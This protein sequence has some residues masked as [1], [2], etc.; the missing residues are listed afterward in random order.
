M[1]VIIFKHVALMSL[2]LALAGCRQEQERQTQQG[3][4]VHANSSYQQHFGDP[5]PVQA[6]KAYARVIYLPLKGERMLVRAIPVYLFEE[7]SQLESI[8]A[9]LTDGKLVL[10]AD[11]PLYVPVPDGAELAIGSRQNG[12][13]TLNLHISAA[14]SL[15]LQP[16]VLSLT[17]T[18]GQFEDISRVLIE[19]NGKPLDFMPNEGFRPGIEHI[20]EVGPPDLVMI[21]GVW[22]ENEPEPEEVMVNFNRPVKIN[23]FS[24]SIADG[25]DVAGEYFTS[26][27]QMAVV[28]RPENPAVLAEGTRL[29][30]AWNVTDAL[31]RTAA[32]E[33]ILTLQRYVREGHVGEFQKK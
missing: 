27:F 29:K 10:P 21:A 16:L 14:I 23:S 22:E 7:Q 11:S 33:E 2:I 15:D 30:V 13:L 19:M 18:A 20:D 8:L 24:L 25:R 1:K 31:G 9:R 17:E 5:P 6:G 12:A 28:V 26:V 32:G 4:I 3:G